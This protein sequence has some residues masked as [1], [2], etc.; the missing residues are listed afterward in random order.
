MTLEPGLLRSMN[1]NQSWR[2]AQF[3]GCKANAVAGVGNPG[4]YFDLL[5]K[6]RIKVIEHV[7]PD[8]HKYDI[9][10][11]AEMDQSL[12]ILMTEKDAVKCKKLGLKNAWCLSVNAVLP[13]DWER[14]LVERVAQGTANTANRS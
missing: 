3:A 5:R 2:L 8:H 7:F 13:S 14:D 1:D 9:G 10:D 4:R 6:A 11:F 12:P